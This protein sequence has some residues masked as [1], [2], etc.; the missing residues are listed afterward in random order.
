[1]EV[2][3]SRKSSLLSKIIEEY[4][5]TA[6]P[7][8]SKMLV[9]KYALDRSSATIRNDMQDLEELG[10]IAQPHTS[11]GRIPTEQGYRY[12][13]ANFLN[14]QQVL[15]DQFRDA[16][17]QLATVANNVEPER[18]VKIL[19]KGIAELTTETVLVGFSPENFYYTGISNMFRK[20]EFNNVEVLYSLSE[21]IDHLDET[22]AQVTRQIE[23]NQITISV[24]QD[25]PISPDCSSLIAASDRGVLVILGPM[26]MNYQANY[27]LLKYAQTLLTN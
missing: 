11:A 22:M 7:V 14:R 6:K 25:N 20:P 26:R 2:L 8:S 27:Q 19:A 18:F 4:I 16:L 1:M 24:G 3:N 21:L 23:P 15:Q 9:E 12:Y 10:F 5:A 17:D 13:I